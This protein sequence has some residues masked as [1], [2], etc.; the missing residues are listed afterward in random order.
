MPAT[1]RRPRTWHD[2][3]AANERAWLDQWARGT[4]NLNT[5]TPTPRRIILIPTGGPR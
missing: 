3:E 4:I 2:L 1:T 5:L